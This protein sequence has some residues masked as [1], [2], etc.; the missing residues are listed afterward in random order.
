[1]RFYYPEFYEMLANDHKFDFTK[2]FS[3]RLYC[4]VH[5]IYS[6]PTCEVCGKPMTF[7]N[8]T[9]GY[10]RLC[11]HY[12]SVHSPLKILKTKRTNLERYGNEWN[13]ASKNNRD[14]K[15]ATCLERY[16]VVNPAK[17]E[18]SKQK[19]K[20]TC[21][22][23][24]GVEYALQSEIIKKKIEKNLSTKIWKKACKF[25]RP[26]RSQRQNNKH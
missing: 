14:K 8:A 5:K 12:C 11:S 9:K 17:T 21:L 7:I 25:F 1:M 24:F 3:E 4:Y 20:G 13:I 18:Q 23:K 15:D 26:K 16:G 19:K 2:N 6:V 22:E 10:H